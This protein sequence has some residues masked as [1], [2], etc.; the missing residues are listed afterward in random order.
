M[1]EFDENCKDCGEILV[2]FDGRH[3]PKCKPGL[4]VGMRIMDD[5]ICEPEW[6][7]AK[8]PLQRASRYAWG[9]TDR[10]LFLGVVFLL[11]LSPYA[12]V[13]LAFLRS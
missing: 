11:V 5:W 12:I 1:T 13:G 7:W 2:G 3:C 6:E 9:F 8:I 10:C 4:N